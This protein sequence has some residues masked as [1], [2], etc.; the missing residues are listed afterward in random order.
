MQPGARWHQSIRI[1]VGQA[2][3]GIRQL[4]LHSIDAQRPLDRLIALISSPQ[5][6]MA[7]SARLARLLPQGF[8]L[9]PWVPNSCRALGFPQSAACPFPWGYASCWLPPRK[10]DY[11]TAAIHNIYISTVHANMLGGA[12]FEISTNSCN[13]ILDSSKAGTGF[14]SWFPILNA[15]GIPSSVG[16]CGTA[17]PVLWHTAFALGACRHSCQGGQGHIPAIKPKFKLASNC[18]CTQSAAPSSVPI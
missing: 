8:G 2:P 14:P 18:Q 10:G 15:P 13:P 4:Q 9:P 11:G 5:M 6:L 12:I 3:H 16:R 17:S 7:A 1:N